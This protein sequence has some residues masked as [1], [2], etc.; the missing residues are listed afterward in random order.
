MKRLFLTLALLFGFHADAALDATANFA[1][2]QLTVGYNSAATSV[3]V[4]AGCGAKYPTPPFNATWW[5][6]A[7]YG[8]PSLD[9][10]VEIVRVT[11]ISTDTLTITRGQENTTGH[12][13]NLTGK[14]YTLAQTM[15]AK[16]ITDI[17]ST[18]VDWVNALPYGLTSAGL[19]NAVNA[20]PS[21]GTL[22]LPCGTWIIT[23]TTTLTQP[24]TM[25][26]NGQCSVLQ[27]AGSV[28][29]SVDILLFQ[30]TVG[31]GAFSTF[32]DFWVSAASGTPGR[33]GLHISGASAVIGHLV[34][35]GLRFDQ[36]GGNAIYADGSGL[37]QGVPAVST[38]THSSILGGIVMTNCGDTVRIV[39]NKFNGAGGIDATFIAGASSLL[40][41]GNNLTSD[42]GIHI[43]GNATTV[44]IVENE[45]EPT[46]ATWVGSNGA[47][48]DI[49]GLVS[50]HAADVIVARNSF[51]INSTTANGVRVNYA[52][53]T[54]IFANRFGRGAGAS[55][56]VVVT[57]NATGTTI[58]TN[59]W[60]QGAPYTSMI[61]DSGTGTIVNASFPGASAN[62]MVGNLSLGAQAA[63]ADSLLTASANTAAPPAPP[64]GTL[65]HAVGADSVGAFLLLDGF[66]SG[67]GALIGR[68]AGGTDASQS[69]TTSG[70]TILSVAG[71]GRATSAYSLT[72]VAMNFSADETWSDTANGTRIDW[73]TT[74]DTTTTLTNGLRL[75]NDGILY[76]GAGVALGTLAAKVPI[77]LFTQTADST[78][79][80]NTL[81]TLFGTGVGTLTLP[82]N[83]LIV[84]R[85]IMI[86]LGGY[87]STADGGA[88]T[89][90]LT[91]T[92]GGVTVASGTSGATFTTVGNAGWEAVATITCRTVGAGGTVIGGGN[93][94]TQIA[95]ANPNA[96]YAVATGTAA[97]NTTG[98]LAIDYKLNNG[99]GTG[100]VRTTY[101]LVEV[102]N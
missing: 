15:S 9:P 30:P 16:F 61:S 79:T 19:Q 75:G 26:G 91:L 84:G 41:R 58:G 49:D 6:S 8:D 38:I 60:V 65:L 25:R 93:W 98:T 32:R 72:K 28:G 42:L 54:M 2:C 70:S 36:L 97:A 82:A 31:N 96:V 57:A 40:V 59:D 78:T 48:V 74:P 10:N 88:G 45:L 12:N 18:A 69:V 83:F 90:T 7:D 76:S 62:M 86:R 1:R 89:K 99:N 13:H 52:D 53:R 102:L 77:T 55:K 23:G 95:T 5:D 92:L 50:A 94:S 20:T 66:G 39:D 67:F 37:A 73:Y 71:R 47:V 64:S 51:Q 35:D 56:D 81:T 17:A 44:Q 3:V 29:A 22:F 101:A 34:I 87:I 85:T 27:V 63:T 33:H 46:L 11:G 100:A 14:T 21:G 68:Q 24:I 4:S 43:G 80:A